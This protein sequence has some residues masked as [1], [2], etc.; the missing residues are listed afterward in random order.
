MY[1]EGSHHFVVLTYMRMRIV[2]LAPFSAY[3]TK[4]SVHDR[5]DPGNYGNI[6]KIYGVSLL[7]FFLF[8]AI[9]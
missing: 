3:W 6:T 9:M 1:V 8:V 7:H 4:S 2:S 5:T